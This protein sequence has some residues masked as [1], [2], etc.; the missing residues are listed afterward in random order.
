MGV[1]RE[2]TAA[3]SGSPHGGRRGG[4]HG[5]LSAAGRASSADRRRL[6]KRLTTGGVHACRPTMEPMT[7]TSAPGTGR[8]RCLTIRG[9]RGRRKTRKIL[10]NDPAGCYIQGRRRGH[11]CVRRAPSPQQCVAD[12]ETVQRWGALPVRPLPETSPRHA[13]CPL[14]SRSGGPLG[15]PAPP[16]SP[17]PAALGHRP[18]RARGWPPAPRRLGDPPRVPACLDPAGV[19]PAVVAPPVPAEGVG[20]PGISSGPREGPPLLLAS[21]VL[22]P[23]ACDTRPPWQ[24]PCPSGTGLAAAS[25]TLRWP[26][27][28]RMPQALVLA[29]QEPGTLAR[30]GAPANLMPPLWSVRATPPAPPVAAASCGTSSCPAAPAGR[31]PPPVPARLTAGRRLPAL[32]LLDLAPP[33]G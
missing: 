6:G 18:R 19:R 1:A 4:R 20:G 3:R 25:P 29:G 26:A 22:L 33:R 2:V 32:R 5:P 11:P 8:D 10:D 9:R 21:G 14:P 27:P 16:V 12:G 30:P 28:A 7:P 31:R 15:P 24:A 13:P 17:R 23:H